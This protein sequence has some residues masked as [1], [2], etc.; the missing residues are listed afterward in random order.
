MNKNLERFENAR[1]TNNNYISKND[2]YINPVEN[3]KRKKENGTGIDN[4]K[5]GKTFEIVCKM[6]MNNIKGRLI[7]EQTRVDSRK[8]INGVNYSFEYK[9]G[10]GEIHGTMYNLYNEDKEKRL[11]ACDL[12][13][14]LNWN[15]PN[16]I[17][18][19]TPEYNE[20]LPIKSYLKVSYCIPVTLLY[21]LCKT[22]KKQIIRV[23]KTRPNIIRWCSDWKDYVFNIIDKYNL[24][25]LEQFLST[26]NY[27]SYIG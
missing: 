17:M 20:S 25:T 15:N 22:E 6:L 24:P 16:I 3:A 14:F 1:K 7:S 26:E 13:E 19:Y 12:V 2:I 5:G 18:I 11:K 23:S 27:T 8:K 21:N 10:A 9:T 4:G